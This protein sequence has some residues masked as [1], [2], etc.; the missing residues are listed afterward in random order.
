MNGRLTGGSACCWSHLPNER[1]AIA[2]IAHGR[3]LTVDGDVPAVLEPLD[4]HLEAVFGELIAHARCLDVVV[5]KVGRG[6]VFLL[7]SSGSDTR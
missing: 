7:T 6:V 3:G 1:P 4:E 2:D 5:A